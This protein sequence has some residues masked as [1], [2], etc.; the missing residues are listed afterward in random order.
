MLPACPDIAAAHR[1][2]GLDVAMAHRVA[3]RDLSNLL[4]Q[5][6]SVREAPTGTLHPSRGGGENP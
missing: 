5:T 4:G 1:R 3:R 6:G 2:P